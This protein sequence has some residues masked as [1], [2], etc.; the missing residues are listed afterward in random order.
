MSP[1]WV[2]IFGDIVTDV[3]ADADKPAG[4]DALAPYYDFGHPVDIVN[5]LKQKDTSSLKFNKFPLIALLMDFTEVMGEDMTVRARTT[6]LTIVIITN[7][8]PELFTNERYD[9]NFRTILYPLYDL[10]IKHITKS[11]YFKSGPGLVSHDKFDRPYWGRTGI[12]GNEANMLNT[13]VD[14]IEVANL[15][16]S[17][18]LNNN[19]KNKYYGL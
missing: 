3:R 6:D 17:L 7:T 5:K 10:L 11:K 16:L 1:F 14:A 18:R 19:C 9:Q 4:L 15:D 13:A 12:S 2:D 8:A